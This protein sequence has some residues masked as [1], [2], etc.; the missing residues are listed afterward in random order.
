MDP[1]QPAYPA[2]PA[3]T[4]GVADAVD[5]ISKSS[6][7]LGAIAA[8]L[9]A[10][11]IG[12]IV[13]IILGIIA[14]KKAARGREAVETSG[15]ALRGKGLYISGKIMGWVGV[16]FGAFMTLYYGFVLAM[17]L[18]AYRAAS[19]YQHTSHGGY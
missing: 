2:P 14:V 19:T 11:P 5:P 3:P 7:I 9:P 6:M 10:V 8:C 15:G 16:G 18:L 1:S 4:P 13:A 12:S 17:G